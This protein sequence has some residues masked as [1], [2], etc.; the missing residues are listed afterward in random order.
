VSVERAGAVTSFVVIESDSWTRI[1]HVPGPIWSLDGPQGE[2]FFG[3]PEMTGPVTQAI[4]LPRQQ[5]AAAEW[6]D[7]DEVD[8]DWPDAAP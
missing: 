1:R 5:M 6:R 2:L 4:A 7:I 8:P 3:P